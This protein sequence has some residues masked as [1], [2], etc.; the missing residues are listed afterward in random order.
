MHKI[1]N[2]LHQV[3]VQ[4]RSQLCYLV[5]QKQKG[6]PVHHHLIPAMIAT[7][8]LPVSL[9]RG[10]LHGRHVSAPFRRAERLSMNIIYL[11][12]TYEI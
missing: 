11:L 3:A 4:H 12:A 5:L 6:P 7:T 8:T 1:R 10:T 2:L 9:P